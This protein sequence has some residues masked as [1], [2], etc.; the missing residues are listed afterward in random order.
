MEAVIRV[1]HSVCRN[2]GVDPK[3]AVP[4]GIARFKRQL[5]EG[6]EGIRVADPTP[7]AEAWDAVVVEEWGHPSG[8]AH[9]SQGHGL[10]DG[11]WRCLSTDEEL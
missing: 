4:Y 8:L 1:M 3:A 10:L 11:V 6:R 7:V 9:D 5:H 2:L